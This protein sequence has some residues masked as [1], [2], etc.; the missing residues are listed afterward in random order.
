[1]EES[2]EKKSID[3]DV[4]EA[5]L[6]LGDLEEEDDELEENFMKADDLEV[7]IILDEG[8]EGGILPIPVAKVRKS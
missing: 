3:E 7:D 5:L 1:M 6:L 4:E 8:V 2:K